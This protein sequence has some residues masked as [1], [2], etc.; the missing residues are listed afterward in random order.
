MESW[1]MQ[2]CIHSQCRLCQPSRLFET[3]A[4]DYLATSILDT[5]DMFR[6][7]KREISNS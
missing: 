4:S 2:V 6:V 5:L 3:N 1:G 7:D